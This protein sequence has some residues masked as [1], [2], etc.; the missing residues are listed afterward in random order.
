M[1]QRIKPYLMILPSL[2]V[3]GILFMGG[4]AEGFLESLGL[5][6]FHG[7]SQFT[8]KYYERV[9]K[10]VD[11]WK[12]LFLTFRIAVLS[13][14]IATAV[15]MILLFFLF[16]VRFGKHSFMATY[17]Q[18][19]FQI[20][21]LFPYLVSGYLI[22]T[23]FT[24]SGWF[25]RLV[26]HMGFIEEIEQFP[27]LVND[28]FGWGIIMAYVWKT[29]PF[30]VLMLYPVIM[31]VKFSWIEAGKVLGA[32]KGQFFIQVV[33][34]LMLSPM[35]LA[36]FIVFSFTFLA[37][38]IPYLLGVTYP[39]TL[40]VYSYQLYMSGNLLDRP[41]ALAVN[42]FA[43]IITGFIGLGVYFVIGI[44][45]ALGRGDGHE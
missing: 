18:R 24:Q 30:I 41:Q 22:F 23:L 28:S 40:S 19:V 17:I 44:K 31:K 21:M 13:T 45:G 36:S 2:V 4:L 27:I 20:P 43:I 7:V 10:D 25:S 38:E 35:K 32:N 3:M 5:T 29:A 37:F 6:S 16:L 9:L 33:I 14:G 15:A 39:K 26:F 11:F 34:P 1:W 12:S 42:I 8:F